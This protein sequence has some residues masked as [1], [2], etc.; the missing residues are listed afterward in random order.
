MQVLV[1]HV[2][3]VGAGVVIKVVDWHLPHNTGQ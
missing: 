2:L 3:V 1:A